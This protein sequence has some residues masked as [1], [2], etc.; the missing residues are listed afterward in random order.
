MLFALCFLVILIGYAYMRSAYL[1]SMYPMEHSEYVLKYAQEYDVDPALIF[2]IIKTE[3]S[4]DEG[5]LS[6]AN[7]QGLMQITDATK[8]FIAEKAGFDVPVGDEILDPETNIKFGVFFI[9]WLINDFENETDT[10]VAAY[11]AGRARVVQW[12]SNESY[13]HDGKTLYYIPFEET[14][15]YVKKI[16]RAFTMYQNLYFK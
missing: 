5:A 11:N 6:G 7:A 8:N 9:G 13:S 15:N 16:R 1:K 10:A 3:S 14:R 12:L 2:A 4:F